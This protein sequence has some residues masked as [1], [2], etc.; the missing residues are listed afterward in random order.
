MKPLSPFLLV[1]RTMS[2]RSIRP[3]PTSF[4]ASITRFLVML[5][6]TNGIH[7]LGSLGASL[8]TETETVLAEEAIMYL[9]IFRWVISNCF[10][11]CVKS[12]LIVCSSLNSLFVLYI[13]ICVKI[14]SILLFSHRFMVSDEF[15]LYYDS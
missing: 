2:T 12:F 1:R 7:R 14:I 13:F 6:N 3:R 9:V 4:K 8:S 15:T 10:E 11:M 5:P